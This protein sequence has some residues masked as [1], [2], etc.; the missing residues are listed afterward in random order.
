MANLIDQDQEW[1]LNCLNA[2]LDPNQEIRSL[3]EVSLRQAS[4]QPGH[5]PPL[6]P[7]KSPISVQSN[8]TLFLQVLE[9]HYQKL[10]RT[11][12]ILLDCVRYPLF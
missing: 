2:T 6:L 9:W 3:A 1:L 10:L 11:R 12:N 5:S 4:L 7:S 8:R